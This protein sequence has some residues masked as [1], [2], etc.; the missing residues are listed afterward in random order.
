M[1]TMTIS[2]QMELEMETEMLQNAAEGLCISLLEPARVRAHE[3]FGSA[4]AA[5]RIQSCLHIL[6]A[7]HWLACE[8]TREEIE[9]VPPRPQGPPPPLLGAQGHQEPPPVVPLA[10]S[11]SSAGPIELPRSLALLKLIQSGMGREE[12]LVAPPAN[13]SASDQSIGGSSASPSLPPGSLRSLE[14]LRRIQSGGMQPVQE[15]AEEEAQGLR[16]QLAKSPDRVRR[17]DSDEA[18]ATVREMLEGERSARQRAVQEADE[19]RQQVSALR[20]APA[21][22]GLL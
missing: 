5:D 8:P 1:M 11:S 2:T 6:P 19:L 4:T 10:A 16:Q 17:T 15:A 12:A 20:D 22:G 13:G 14:L 21:D 7:P 9:V 3:P 18:L